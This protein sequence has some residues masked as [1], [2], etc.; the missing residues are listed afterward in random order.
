MKNIR[1]VFSKQLH[2]VAE[3]VSLP[4]LSLLLHQ[5]H[6]GSVLLSRPVVL[7]FYSLY[8]AKQKYKLGLEYFTVLQAIICVNNE[9]RSQLQNSVFQHLHLLFELLVTTSLNSFPRE[10][11]PPVYFRSI[12][13]NARVF[14]KS[15][16]SCGGS[17]LLLRCSPEMLFRGHILFVTSFF[18]AESASLSFYS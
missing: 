10:E 4:W 3:Q 17:S 14:L 6:L 5:Q 18:W 13:E 1:L 15:V 11:S 8:C 7:H 16:A 9:L 2:Q 12:L